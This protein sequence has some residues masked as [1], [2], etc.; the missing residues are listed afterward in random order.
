MDSPAEHFGAER[1]DL[2]EVEFTQDL[3]A[4]VPG[5]YAR[6]YRV[7]PV[8]TRPG[9]IVL[10]LDDPSDVGSIDALHQLLNR[11]LEVCIADSIQLDE[12]IERLYGT[13]RDR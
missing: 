11:D 12:F 2:K 10:A 1:I 5:D 7:L 6:R 4:A 8:S 9:V 3:L 13:S